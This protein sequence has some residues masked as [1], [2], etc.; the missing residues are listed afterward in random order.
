VSAES[1]THP[2]PSGAATA[3]APHVRRRARG[4][5]AAL[6]VTEVVSWG[7][8]YYAFAAFL[9][10]MQHELGYSTAQLTGAF[11]LALLISG[12]AGIAVGRYLDAHSP[13][14]LMTIGSIAATVLVA[15]WSQIDG[16]VAFYLVWT[17]LGL[18]MAAILYE[19]AFVVLAKWFPDADER[20]RAM[21]ALTLVAALAS[22]IFLPLSQALIDAHGWR[23]ALL[24]LAAILAVITVPLH[25]LALRGAPAAHQTAKRGREPDADAERVLRS[26]SFWLFT[27]AFFLATTTGIAMTILAIPYLIERG[28]GPEFAA[29]AV[30][31]VGLSQIPGR[32]VFAVLGGR[33]PRALALPAVFLFIALG[34][35]ALTA[36]DGKALVIGALVLLGMGNG[37]TTLARATVIADRYGSAAYGA[38]SSVAASA[39]TAARAVGPVAAAAYAAATGYPTLLWTLA[40]LT[41]VAGVLAYRSERT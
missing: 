37:M 10:P 32:I 26:R 39:T 13:R 40:A 28:Y 27:A 18:T 1:H 4:I 35:A 19:P 17:G 41:L 30:G 34:I 7:V 29:F 2:Q 38:I 22:F 33:L 31:L 15:A 3:V 16:L 14:A 21:T 9:V 20:R 6:S 23:G 12:G 24:I 36:A 11:S 25:A 5:V 8:V